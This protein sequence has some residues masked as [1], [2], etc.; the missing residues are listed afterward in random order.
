MDAEE[1]L[2]LYGR[3]LCADGA[4]V[5]QCLVVAEYDKA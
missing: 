4:A 2:A 1:Q 5:G 3:D